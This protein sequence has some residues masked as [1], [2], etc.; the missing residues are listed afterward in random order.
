VNARPTILLVESDRRLGEALASQLAAD[1]YAVEL[2]RSDRHARLLAAETPPSLVLLGHL[3]QP[4]SSLPLLEEIRAWASAEPGWASAVPVL[5]MGSRHSELELLRAFEA[6]ADDF[7]A[8]PVGYLELRARIAAIL[9][10]I[11][12]EAP[13]VTALH[14]GELAVDLVSR[15]AQL[16]ERPLT[17]R[18]MEFELLAKLAADPE[19]TFSRE[20][21][22][23]DVWGYR[24]PGTRTRTIDTHASRLRLKMRDGGAWI[25]AVWGVGYR[26]R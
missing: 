6:G 11:D 2:A 13:S 23:R 12:A 21:L 24:S 15:R 9:R 18:R 1:D 20:E 22:L 4:R 14:V 3:E 19:R 10:R 25:L 26:L 16:A 8:K 5:V 17:L 7:V